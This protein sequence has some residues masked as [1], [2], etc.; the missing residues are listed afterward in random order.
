[1][2]AFSDT[3]ETQTFVPFIPNNLPEATS[4]VSEETPAM[5]AIEQSVEGNIEGAIDVT[6][7]TGTIAEKEEGDVPRPEEEVSNVEVAQEEPQNE[8]SLQ[9]SPALEPMTTVTPEANPAPSE[10][11][12]PEAVVPIYTPSSEGIEPAAI[13][14]PEVEIVAEIEDTVLTTPTESGLSA[15]RG[16]EPMHSGMSTASEDIRVEYPDVQENL[17]QTESR[18]EEVTEPLEVGS[19]GSGLPSVS[20]DQPH[21]S[22]AA[23]AKRQMS[24]PLMMT[25]DNNKELV[26]FF[27][28]RVTN[29]LFSED[30]FNKNSP[31]YKSLENTFLELVGKQA[32]ALDV[33]LLHTLFSYLLV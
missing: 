11:T 6:P 3:P 16:D 5:A 23:P 33:M 18:T 22:T 14:E 20:E 17:G 30:L 26:V 24:T 10:S 8:E 29:M 1:M 21:E 32:F 12:D 27:S 7:P 4:G 2:E 19:S 25:A 31:E 13:L 9:L 28:L 15:E